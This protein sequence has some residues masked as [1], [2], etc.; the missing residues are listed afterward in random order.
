MFNNVLE[1]L[2]EFR[3]LLFLELHFNYR[4]YFGG[5]PVVN[6]VFWSPLP[7]N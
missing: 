1:R 3:K 6:P 5:R 7:M 2:P 4:D